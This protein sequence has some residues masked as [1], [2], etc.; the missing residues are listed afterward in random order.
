MKQILAFLRKGLLHE[1]S[2]KM[3]M[4]FRI[5]AWSLVLLGLSVAGKYI[6]FMEVDEIA[7][8]Q[9]NFF[10]FLTSGFIFMDIAN[11]S[12]QAFHKAIRTEQMQGTLEYL[13]LNNIKTSTLVLGTGIPRYIIVLIEKIIIILFLMLFLGRI[14]LLFQVPDVILWVILITFLAILGISGIG[15]IFAG[16][17]FAFQNVEAVFNAFSI[18]A[19]IFSGVYFPY[20][21]LPVW[22]RLGNVLPNTHALEALRLLLLNKQLTSQIFE[23][24][25]FLVVLAFIYLLV[26]NLVFR[27]GVYRARREGSLTKY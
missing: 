26:G 11:T 15:M 27:L 4:T 16:L 23:K 13:L 20:E 25:V 3:N 24:I 2:Y 22:L 5:I 18:F 21:I 9:G 12:L 10:L 19:S 8:Y 6:K 14:S 7:K 17:A 1:F